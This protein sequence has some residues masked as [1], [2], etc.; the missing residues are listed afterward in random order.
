MG[1]LYRLCIQQFAEPS[2]N[3]ASVERQLDSPVTVCRV[4]GDRAVETD[5]DLI[6]ICVSL[7]QWGLG[8]YFGVPYLFY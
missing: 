7:H 5:L 8:D 2:L 6:H 3:K 1:L 4:I